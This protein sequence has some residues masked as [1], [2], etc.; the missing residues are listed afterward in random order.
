MSV[1]KRAFIATFSLGVI[2]VAVLAVRLPKQEYVEGATKAW[3]EPVPEN[4][5]YG[6]TLSAMEYA[7]LI[8]P[9]L[10]IPPV[11]DCGENV[12][13]PIYIDGVKNKGNPGLHCC[14]NPSLQAGD[15]MSGSS[16]Q[17][18]EGVTADG[19]PLPHVVWVSFCRHEGRPGSEIIPNP[20]SV[21]LIGYNTETG[22]TAFFERGKT[23]DF[24]YI[25]P[26][27]NRLMGKLPGTDDPEA[28]NRAYTT[29]GRTQCVSCHQ[30]NPFIHNPYIDAAKLPSDPSETVIP[31]VVERSTPYYVIGASDWDMRT[32]HIEGN[33]CLECH[34]IGM[35]TVELF[36][37]NHWHPNDHMPPDDPGSLSNDFQELL[38]CWQIGPESTPDCEWIIPPAGDALGRVVGDEYPY[39]A[40][41]NEPGASPFADLI[42]LVIANTVVLIA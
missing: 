28:F 40:R 31:K 26:E 19:N 4:D 17:R 21:Q 35:K 5:N 18:Y 15:C 13:I 22:A 41:F 20:N 7:E 29:P 24:T 10:G 14:D 1:S 27:T 25:D 23:I 37:N 16:V 39:K 30:S 38:D 36:M 33:G 42:P 8:E 12:E 32:I 3:K 9:E 34:R 6:V 2:L 11:V